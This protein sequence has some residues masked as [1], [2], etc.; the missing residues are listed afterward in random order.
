MFG[1]DLFMSMYLLVTA[2]VSLFFLAT[3]LI[4]LAT[5]ATDKIA[6]DSAKETLLFV[7]VGAIFILCFYVVSLFP[8][9]V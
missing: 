4:T 3:S 7:F 8:H 2:A 1:F 5:K 9:H 6:T